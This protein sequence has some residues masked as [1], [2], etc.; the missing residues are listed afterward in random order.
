MSRKWRG[1]FF[2]K[3]TPNR[4]F[5]TS[6][7]QIFYDIFYMTI[8]WVISLLIL[9][10][11]CWLIIWIIIWLIYMYNMSYK[12]KKLIMKIWERL[13]PNRRLGV[14]FAKK[15]FFHK[16][17]ALIY[18]R[19]IVCFRRQNKIKNTFNTI[20]KAWIN[21]LG[22]FQ[23]FPI[24]CIWNISILEIWNQPLPLRRLVNFCSPAARS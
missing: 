1:N 10:V 23:I 13:V 24:F 20:A 11:I 12:K 22:I 9:W 8:I 5:G 19:H 14:H 4:R 3:C 18:Y 7:S 15:N 21:F 16:N 2:R 17:D 6:R